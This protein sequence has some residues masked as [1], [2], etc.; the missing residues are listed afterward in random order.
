[1]STTTLKLLALALMVLDHT[2][3]FI[4]GIPIWFRWLGRLSAPIF[5]FC[6]AWGFKYTHDRKHYMVRM[7][8][9]SVGMALMDFIL[10]NLY[11]GKAIIYITNNIFTTLFLVGAIVWILEIRQ[12]D[13]EKGNRLV[14]VFVLYQ[15]AC[16]FI[17]S[18]VS[19]NVI[20][21]LAPQLVYP[22][23]I[24]GAV[25]GNL[26]T[27]EGG[28]IFVILGVLIYF[29]KDTNADITKAYGIFCGIFFLLSLTS[30]ISYEA[31]FLINF[32]WMMVFALPFM[33]MYNGQK[34]KGFKY[35]FYIIY[36][37]HIAAL[38][39]IGNMMV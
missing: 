30:G 8:L 20:S 11:S 2:A 16:T 15:L 32:Q 34:G 19:N 7:Y 17:I 33:L 28:F 10:N 35:L 23:Q 26:F 22:D 31:L 13:K 29:Y 12:K 5:M 25:T 14:A 4:P 37:V 36:P 21:S 38:F 6:M 3:E 39:I 9:F 18:L 27:A 1:M 24:L